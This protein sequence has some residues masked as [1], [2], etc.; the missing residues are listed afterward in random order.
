LAVAPS[1]LAKLLFGS[2]LTK[3][4][5]QQALKLLDAREPQSSVARLLNVDQSAIS[6]LIARETVAA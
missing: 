1:L 5:Q 3:H 2:E 6:R 4:Q